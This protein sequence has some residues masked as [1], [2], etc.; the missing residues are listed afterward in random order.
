MSGPTR[1]YL[2][3]YWYHVYSRGQRGQPL[4]FSPQDRIEYLKALDNEFARVGGKIGS[5]CI[6]TNHMHLLL[7]MEDT[8]LGEVLRNTNSKYARAF[9][10]RR[11]LSGHVV[12]S[13]PGVKLVLGNKYLMT[14]VGYVHFN[15][16][17]AGITVQ[18]KDFKWSSWF[19]FEGNKCPWIDLKSWEYPPGFKGKK[20]LELFRELT[21]KEDFDL[22]VYKNFVGNAKKW[23]ALDKRTEKKPAGIFREKRNRRAIEEILKEVIKNT[24]YNEKIIR[25]RIRLRKISKL[26]QYAM[27]KMW[28]EGHKMSDIA[29]FFNCTSAAVHKAI[30]KN[31]LKS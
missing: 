17:K 5:F 30:N 28:D 11:G 31:K 3:N 12:Q 7:K 27:L 8:S 14:L 29:R 21:E 20:R 18:V 4:F 2:K 23:I 25:S 10:K 22:P 13:R 9:N 24:D 6:M 1:I 19:W 15:P 26:R 16:V